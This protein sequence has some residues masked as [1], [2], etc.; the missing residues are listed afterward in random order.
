M[1]KELKIEEMS[2]LVAED[3]KSSGVEMNDSV[4]KLVI[5]GYITQKKNQFLSGNAVVE[6]GIGTQ[7]PSYRRVSHA[8]NP[9]YQY[10]AKMITDMD[11]RL[12]DAIIDKLSSDADFRVAVGAT[13]L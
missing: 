13:E 5:E 12:K 11:Y 7:R 3:L 8:F 9:K 4:V 1:A 2:S 10:T 6:D